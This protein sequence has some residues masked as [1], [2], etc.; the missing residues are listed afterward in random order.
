M[1]TGLHTCEA[2]RVAMWHA[3]QGLQPLEGGLQ[4]ETVTKGLE[5]LA[6]SSKQYAAAGLCA[7]A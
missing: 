2:G 6:E 4:G 7:H 3:T 1:L 5:T